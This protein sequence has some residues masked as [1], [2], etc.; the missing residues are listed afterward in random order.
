VSDSAAHLSEEVK[1]AAKSVP[2]AMMWSFVLNG[3]VGFIVLITF[4]FAVPNIS[5]TLDPSLNP[6]GFAFLYVFQQA[7][8][9]GS[10][11]LTAM[12]ISVI[13]A[14]IIDS[15]ASTSRQVFAFAR[16]GGFPLQSWL[17]KV[18]PYLPIIDLSS[19]FI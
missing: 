7:S 14:G 13:V 8:Y 9:K 18:C 2:R 4:L 11:P 15:N 10:I 16:D 19:I 12:I 3:L 17:S 6:S 1:T 5:N